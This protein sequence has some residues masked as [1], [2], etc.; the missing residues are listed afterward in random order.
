VDRH[1]GRI[2]SIGWRTDIALRELEGAEIAAS[3]ENLV[4][5]TPQNRGYRW[6]NFIL[7]PAAPGPGEANQC[8]RQFSA[9]F[10]DA[11]YVAIGFDRPPT[12]AETLEEFVSLGLRVDV[13]TVLT[14]TSLTAPA[15]EAPAAAFRRLEGDS[16][17]AQ[18][19]ALSLA[20]EEPQDSESHRRYLARR[21]GAIRR[22]CEGGHGAWFGA[23]RDG[24]MHCGLGVFNVGAG[25]ARFQAVDT[26]PAHRR[27]GLASHL[28]HVAGQYAMRHLGARTLVIAADP[29]YHA[30]GI[31]RSLGFQDHERHVQVER[32]TRGRMRSAGEDASAARD[33]VG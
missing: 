6:G 25:L 19:A 1:L 4:I 27:Q 24:E 22:V 32:L 9:A 17:W 23:F 7:L 3:A 21:M 8:V 12:T 10:P 14:A 11:G 15:R 29:D 20:T 18:A 30:I 26:H 2:E 5:R 13:D 31:Y 33:S 28:L 16:D